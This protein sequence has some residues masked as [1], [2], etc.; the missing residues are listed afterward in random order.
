V[1]LLLLFGLGP[2]GL[3]GAA[4][5][6]DWKE[7]GKGGRRPAA[8]A[9]KRTTEAAPAAG[10]FSLDFVDAEIVEVLK[11]LATMTKVNIAVSSSVT[12]KTTVQ[13]RNVTLEDA[14]DI[15]T[16]LN[17]LD[18]AWVKAAYVVGKPEE[19]R[20]MRVGE[21][22]TSLVVLRGADPEEARGLL[23]RLTP[24]VT[25][26]TQK[27]SRAVFMIGTEA[28]LR[29]AEKALA[30]MDV[31]GPPTTQRLP[32]S[33]AKAGKVQE[34]IQAQMPDVSAELLEEENTLV[35]TADGFQMR[36]VKELVAAL[37]VKPEPAQ[38]TRYVYPIKYA[39]ATELKDALVK[40]LPDLGVTL[41]PRTST[42][43]LQQGAGGGGAGG[44]V[45]LLAAPQLAGGAG[46]A[47][48]GIG[49]AAGGQLEVAPVTL[50]I[51]SG[52]PQTLERALAILEKIDLPPR[53][54]KITALITEIRQE[55]AKSLGIDWGLDGGAGGIVTQL[56]EQEYF[57]ES[58]TSRALEFGRFVR[59]P[60]GVTAAIRALATEG[61]ANIL[62]NPSV[63]TLDGRQ[64]A[65]HTGETVYY[66]VTV[67]ASPA[68]GGGTV[69]DVRT[70]NVG[71][72]LTVN[73]RISPDGTIVLTVNPVVADISGRSIFAGNLPVVT[74]KSAVTTVRMKDKET[75]VIAGLISNQEVT[76]ITRVP[77]LSDIPLLGDLLF[78]HKKR[79]PKHK[80]VLIFV[81]PE[82]LKD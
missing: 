29:K 23:A 12:G 5:R 58:A 43:I 22:E 63:V 1:G 70:F 45:A 42:P 9:G 60:I 21:L 77:L 81:T 59:S 53:K 61:R 64:T 76:T 14:L 32:I 82:L 36:Q 78:T 74:E 7:G 73:P 27:D 72:T 56:G 44:T 11:A 50:L 16:K 2:P 8:A 55:D 18:Y 65:F 49:Q 62:S 37:D 6:E 10:R 30:A 52:A 68:A 71:V 69:Q 67:A 79:E 13:L 66:E 46:G 17:G 47:A 31:P 26:S 34:I 75:L 4:A 33:Y 24:G 57:A 15:V 19:V 39:D 3:G 28:E 48:G 80:E 25:V 35:V 38:A 51:L 40:L 54:V 20:A 41:G